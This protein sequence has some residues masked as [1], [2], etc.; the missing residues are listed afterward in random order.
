MYQELLQALQESETSSVTI[1]TSVTV[2]AVRKGLKA[3]IKY[4]N[5]TSALLEM[6]TED[7]HVSI[8]ENEDGS[9]TI[10]LTDEPTTQRFE[11]KFQFQIVGDKDEKT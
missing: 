11:S 9:M 2:S 10:S 5:Q 7:R 8:A 4:S 6:P 1:D 3:R